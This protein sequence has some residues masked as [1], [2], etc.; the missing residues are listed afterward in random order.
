MKPVVIIQVRMSSTR[1]PGKVLK[2]LNGITVLESLLNQLNYS[3]LLNDKIIA[4]T[5]NS[6][7]DVIVNFCK[8][9]EI[10]CFRGSQDD[11]LDRY[12]NC[13]KK[14]SINTILRI[15]S[16]CPLMDPQVVDNVIDFYLKNSYDYVNNFYKRTYPYGNDVEIFSLKVLEK[17]WEKATKPSEREHV[18]P[19]IYNNPDEFSLG[20]I[21]NKENL[22]EFHWTID[23]KEDLIFVQNIFKKISK[24]PI[25]MKDIIDV[26]KDDPSLLEINK[27]TNPNEGYL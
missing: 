6:E 5:S 3:K 24:R 12:Y 7:D 11:V 4:T 8:S 15:T 13:A 19:Y 9:K 23:R 16:D 1:L 2:K 27:N 10:K 25:L 14:F 22:S 20:W 26:I 17:V 18:T 21:E